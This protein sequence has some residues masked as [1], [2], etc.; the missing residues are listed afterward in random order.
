MDIFAILK[1]GKEMQSVI[2]EKLKRCKDFKDNQPPEQMSLSY[3]GTDLE[4]NH[5]TLENTPKEELVLEH[6]IQFKR[7]F[8]LHYDEKRELFV[9]PKN[10]CD[11]YKFICT[12]IR[13]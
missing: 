10:E 5:I 7:Q 8:Q 3:R 2:N 11:V 13:P 6:V 12:T 4:N 9:F 1:T